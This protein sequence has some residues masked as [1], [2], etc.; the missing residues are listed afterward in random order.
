MTYVKFIILKF[1]QNYKKKPHGVR[2]VQQGITLDSSAYS[3][4][5]I[6]L[7]MQRYINY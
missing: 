7:S 5:V 2:E 3:L 6:C 1:D 4:V